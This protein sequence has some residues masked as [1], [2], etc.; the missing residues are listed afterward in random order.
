LRRPAANFVS[1]FFFPLRSPKPTPSFLLN[2]HKGLARFFL[3]S[4]ICFGKRYNLKLT[5]SFVAAAVFMALANS[6]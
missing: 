4:E 3:S 5:L 1:P 2:P 6:R